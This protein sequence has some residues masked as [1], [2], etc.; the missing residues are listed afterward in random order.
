MKAGFSNERVF[1][2]QKHWASRLHYDFRLELD[3]T[4][5]SW[6]VPKGPS[7]DPSVR[8]MAIETRDHAIAYNRFEGTI[9]QGQYGAGKVIIWDN[10]I[11]IPEG[12]PQNGY[13]NGQLR[14]T[15]KGCKMRGR[16]ALIR[17]KANEIEKHPSWLLIKA[18]DVYARNECDS[19]GAVQMP[20][21]PV[22]YRSLHRAKT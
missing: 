4:M 6:V 9:P 18:R 21:H 15:L 10:G 5:K 14:F 17:M 1:V 22:L 8:R 3:G 16:W 7:Y 19:S 13:R 12:D 2:I 20:D 11:W